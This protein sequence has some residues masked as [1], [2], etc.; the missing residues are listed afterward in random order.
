M[1]SLQEQLMKAGLA[2]EKNAKKIRKEK[3]K[4]NKAVRK[5]Q[6]AADTSLQDDLKAKK[7][8]Q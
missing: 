6:Q 7:L 3:N 2:D 5:R 4:T 8:A 1:A